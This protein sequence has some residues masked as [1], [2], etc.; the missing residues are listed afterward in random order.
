MTNT[1]LNIDQ[2]IAAFPEETQELLEQLRTTIK[3]AA[4][5]AEEIISYGMPAFRFH[6][7]LVYFAVH[8]NHI[9]FYP[10]ASGIEVF[11][12]EISLYKWAKGSVQF[13]LDKSLPFEL[14]TNIVTF[15]V[16]ENIHHLKTKKNK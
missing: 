13:P 10:G 16:N 6:R 2:Y 15:R 1:P 11:K 14:I 4:P 9:G 12:K 5:E 8:K 3:K 7:I